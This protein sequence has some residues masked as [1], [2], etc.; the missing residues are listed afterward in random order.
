MVCRCRIVYTVTVPGSLGAVRIL[1]HILQLVHIQLTL[2]PL[3][4]LHHDVV[5]AVTGILTTLGAAVEVVHAG[6][7]VQ[8]LVRAHDVTA[9]VE[10]VLVHRAVGQIAVEARVRVADTEG[11]VVI[12]LRDGNVVCERHTSLEELVIVLAGST[13]G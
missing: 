12:H 11:T 7:H 13:P 1:V 5:V 8:L 4:E 3:G 9:H 2:T 10:D 6:E